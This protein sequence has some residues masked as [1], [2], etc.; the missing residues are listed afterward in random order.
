MGGGE[1]QGDGEP[2]LLVV[3]G[4]GEDRTDAAGEPKLPGQVSHHQLGLRGAASGARGQCVVDQDQTVP[5]ELPDPVPPLERVVAPLQHAE[6]AQQLTEQ[7]LR[8]LP[9][10]VEQ[11]AVGGPSVHLPDH[12]L[13]GA[14][15]PVRGE[16]HHARVVAVVLPPVDD[17]VG[18]LGRGEE[19]L[20]GDRFCHWELAC[21]GTMC[22]MDLAQS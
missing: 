3:P 2:A 15:V 8:R 7:A 5:A 9:G 1:A 20:V 18:G 17:A 10:R 19:G 12:C 21:G 14:L 11:E 22:V 16:V 4:H 6:F 13:G